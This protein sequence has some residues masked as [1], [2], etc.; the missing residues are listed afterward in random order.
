MS[1]PT[2]TIIVPPRGE[3]YRM[4]MSGLTGIDNTKT[5]PVYLYDL[6][7]GKAQLMVS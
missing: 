5:P 2:I 4:F 3:I 7:Q 6:Q 1:Y